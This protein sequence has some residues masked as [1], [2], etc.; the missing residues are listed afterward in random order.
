MSAGDLKKFY[1]KSV[2]RTKFDVD[3][4]EKKVV[5]GTVV[6]DDWNN[7]NFDY[8]SHNKRYMC[9]ADGANMV[10]T[11]A[12]N[13]ITVL[14]FDDM[15]LY[16]QACELV[17]DLHTYYT[18]K[19]RK[20][21]HVY[22]E[23]D[24][25]NSLYGKITNI[26]VQSDGSFVFG[27][28]TTVR[29]Y[30]KNNQYHNQFMYTHISGSR[31]FKP[32]PTVLRDWCCTV[33][34]KKDSDVKKFNPNINYKDEVSD[35]ELREILDL[36][37]EK[38]SSYFNDYN[39]WITFTAIMKTLDKK[40][41]WD[42]YSQRHDHRDR[43]NKYK[44]NKCWN[45]MNKPKSINIFCK[46]LG[47]PA[48]KYHKVVAEDELYN[49]VN[50]DEHVMR[51]IDM[52]FIAVDHEDI[53]TNDTI[54]LES[55]TGSGKTTCVA[56]L[57]NKFKTGGED[58][59][60][61]LSIVNLISLANQQKIT[62]AKHG[63]HLKMYNDYSKVNPSI[64]INFDSCICINSLWKL[65][66]CDFSNKIVYIDEIY[67]LCMSLTHNETLHNQRA[68]FNT[69]Y[70]LINECH[71]LIVSD[72]HV[73]NNVIKLLESRL[74]AKGK[75]YVHYLN[76]YQKF[77]ETTALRY[78]DENE[79]FNI[80][81]S[82]VLKGDSFSFGADSKGIVEKWYLKLR[83][84]APLD[85][86]QKMLLYT[87]EEDTEIQE[88]W[89]DKII[90][91][92]PKITTGVD[93]TCINSSEQFMYI[94][95]QSVSSINLLQMATRTRNME[96]LSYYSSVKC[97]ESL[98]DTYD[99]CVA[100]VSANFA[101]NKLGYSFSHLED[102]TLHQKKFMQVEKIH[103][104][105]YVHNTFALD[106]HNTNKL[107]FFEQE[108][109]AC[110][111]VIQRP[112]GVKAKL[113]KAI[114]SEFRVQKQ[115]I[116]DDKYEKLIKCIEE[117]RKYKLPNSLVPLAERC[118]ILKLHKEDE[119]LTY[120]KVVEDD[121]AMSHFLN[122]KG[123][124]T[125]YDVVKE[126]VENTVQNKM[127]AGMEKDRW[128]KIK[129]VHMLAQ[130]CNVGKDVFDIGNVA[131]PELTEKNKT[132][133]TTIKK[134]YDKRDKIDVETYELDSIQKLYRFML[135]NLTKKLGL[136]KSTRSKKKETRDETLYSIDES[137]VEKYDTLIEYM[138]RS[139]YFECLDDYECIMQEEDE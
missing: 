71:K 49:Q 21:M 115:V 107:H 133:I 121:D 66:D 10:R 67:S 41:M 62:F 99:D 20:G 125:T 34:E 86:Q 8:M 110:G 45:S 54:I 103:M 82:K 95:G 90:F 12:Y 53:V 57:F 4:V 87:S 129:Y 94:T 97:C 79:F 28:F 136:I 1:L 109:K 63:T 37:A 80:I 70:R 61:L 100:K 98:Y 93:I 3:G 39:N 52:K 38:H 102:F 132:I 30:D 114:E 31:D 55:G 50:Y 27:N 46:I 138:S 15:E 59:A 9:T 13:N 33:V 85:V 74:Y 42:E 116:S 111:F 22:F 83:N 119:L 104:D 26:D 68:I 19:T 48:I 105:L 81:Q 16:R 131:M 113:D 29:R 47:I 122:Y 128:L 126:N 6:P 124:K 106:L 120:R 118:K 73:H 32:M 24:K 117:P 112:V 72:A 40:E 25:T 35:K 78:N 5:N 127:S 56:K 134:L 135:D 2:L 77:D 23:Y 44:N 65:N 84:S 18:V 64:I 137:M 60:T 89:N 75:R 88:D 36:M 17:P 58:R 139:V 101:L 108:L 130:I 14:D 96:K 69:L 7:D 92:S 11:G 123:L 91:Y 43:Y 76:Q 51:Y